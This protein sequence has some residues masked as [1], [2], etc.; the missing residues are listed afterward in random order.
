VALPALRAAID[1]PVVGVV[2][3][4]KPASRLSVNRRIGILATPA[5]IRR[6]Y[7]D[8][9]ISEFAADCVIERI[10]HSELVHWVEASAA[11]HSPMPLEALSATLQPFRSA[12]VDTVVLGCTHYPLVTETLR[13]QLPGVDH[14]VD[15]GEAI[16]RRTLHLLQAAGFTLAETGLRVPVRTDIRFSGPWPPALKTFIEG[17]GFG[18]DTISLD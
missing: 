13:T 12:Q 2:P 11:G 15:S 7:L 14:W 10:G 3:A 6:P 18:V 8:R 16:A 4:I 1:V 9:L 17:L 5:T